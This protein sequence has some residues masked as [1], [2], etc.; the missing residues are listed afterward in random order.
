MADIICLKLDL[1]NP[2]PWQWSRGEIF[3]SKSKLWEGQ[4]SIGGHYIKHK[5]A[6]SWMENSNELSAF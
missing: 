1:P 5:K 6:V 4:S 2:Q 3:D